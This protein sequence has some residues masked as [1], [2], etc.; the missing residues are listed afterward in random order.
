MLTKSRDQHASRR[1]KRPAANT[2]TDTALEKPVEL[3]RPGIPAL[4]EGSGAVH[5]VSDSDAQPPVEPPGGSEPE[6]SLC[7][8]VREGI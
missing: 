1:V 6:E 4:Y 8:P 5:K 2:R 3:E 7:D